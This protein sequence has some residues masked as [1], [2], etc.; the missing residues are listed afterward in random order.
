M[1]GA[2]MLGA[3]LRIQ[4]AWRNAL[5]RH[6]MR[7]LAM[8]MYQKIVDE[9]HGNQVYYYNVKTGAA[10]WKK[11]V[12]LGKYD[13]ANPIKLP[14]DDRLFKKQCHL[15]AKVAST[16]Y[17]ITDSESF[18]DDCN[19]QVHSKG[20]R[21]K[22]I[23]VKIDNCIQCEFQVASKFC[24]QCKDLYC[25]TCYFDQHKKGMLQKHYFDT[26]Q[27]HCEVCNEYTALLKVNPGDH[28]YCK[29]CY[30][31]EHP[32][33]RD[34]QQDEMH[35][36]GVTVSHYEHMPAAV[37]AYWQKQEED[38]RKSVLE[39]EFQERKKEVR[40]CAQSGP[41]STAVCVCLF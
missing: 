27:S 8:K 9:H 32:W 26:V 18:C 10:I 4:G 30:K 38:A 6:H 23:C 13:I 15:C 35:N 39:A 24:V 31:K 34:Y 14:T 1:A 40:I 22:N 7:L 29:V 21:V 19:E 36:G 2:A 25:D 17:D 41:N 5:S 12:L 16:W 28:S 3:I 33:D 11:P 20:R 37:H